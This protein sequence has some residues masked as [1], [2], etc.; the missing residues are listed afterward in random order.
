MG[1]G[2]GSNF[3]ASVNFSFFSSLSAV[4]SAFA[5]GI[6]AVDAPSSVSD[7]LPTFVHPSSS[8]TEDAVVPLADEAPAGNVVDVFGVKGEEATSLVAVLPFRFL[9]FVD[10]DTA[11]AKEGEGGTFATG[12]GFFSVA[13][14]ACFEVEAYIRSTR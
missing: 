14:D 12:N 2:L 9:L 6:E 13:E 7:A 1:T 5:C 11:G 8:T 4:F 10:V 3:S